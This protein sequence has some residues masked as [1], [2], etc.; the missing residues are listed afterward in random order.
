M[1]ANVEFRVLKAKHPVLDVPANTVVVRVGD[2]VVIVDPGPLEPSKILDTCT[3]GK[4]VVVLL[5]HWHWDHTLTANMLARECRAEVYASSETILMLKDTSRVVEWARQILS[6]AGVK[7]DPSTSIVELF[8]Q[9]YSE[10]SKVASVAKSLEEL[11]TSTRVEPVS[12]PG[13]SKGHVCF[14]VGGELLIAGDSVTE[15]SPPVVEDLASYLQ[16]LSE[17]TRLKWNHLVPGHGRVLERNEALQLIDSIKSRKLRR[18]LTLLNTLIARVDVDGREALTAV[19]GPTSSVVELFTR[20][21]SLL[22]Y[23][24]YLE[25]L[26]A[27]EVDRARQPW[28]LRVSEREVAMQIR[29]QITLMLRSE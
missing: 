29:A 27:I 1:G 3:G 28:R 17:L 20:S 10:A 16:S 23:I 11:I 5:T 18:L 25:S 7:P 15:P 24:G 14:I 6:L 26:G 8:K 22:G 13:H 21:Y 2:E 12:C 19:Y 4:R 9:L